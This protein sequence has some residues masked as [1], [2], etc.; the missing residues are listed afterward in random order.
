MSNSML[1]IYL[2][3][4]TTVVLW[5]SGKCSPGS[6]GQIEQFPSTKTFC[7]TPR[8]LFTTVLAFHVPQ[9]W[10]DDNTRVIGFVLFATDLWYILDHYR[11]T[12]NGHVVARHD[13][14]GELI[15]TSQL[16]DVIETAC[17]TYLFRQLRRV[18]ESVSR[19]IVAFWQVKEAPHNIRVVPVIFSTSVSCQLC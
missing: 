10:W 12:W 15:T 18:F 17:V 5:R 4:K 11:A 3:E 2:V 19:G 14:L 1:C 7:S 13:P 9:W 6:F 8:S 16:C